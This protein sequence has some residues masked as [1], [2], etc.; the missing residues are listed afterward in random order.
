M[1]A[2][3]SSRSAWEAGMKLRATGLLWVA[4]MAAA[5]AASADPEVLLKCDGV[6]PGQRFTNAGGWQAFPNPDRAITIIRDKGKLTLELEG[7]HPISTRAVFPLPQHEIRT[8][9]VMGRDGVQNFHVVQ[10]LYSGQP[11]VKHSIFGARDGSGV[12]NMRET[13]LD[14]C[15]VVSPDVAVEKEV[16]GPPAAEKARR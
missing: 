6:G 10:G 7:E 15:S 11:E 3:E 8:F 9:R 4:A 5:G 14:H 13:T 1:A 16:A 12:F 2:A